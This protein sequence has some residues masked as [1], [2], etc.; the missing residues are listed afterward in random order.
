MTLVKE[1][2][3]QAA[4]AAPSPTRDFDQ[5]L[6]NIAEYGLTIIPDVLTGDVL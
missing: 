1:R 6:R 2:S 3:A 5:G 4:M